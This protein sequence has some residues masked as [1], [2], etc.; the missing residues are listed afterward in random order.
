[1]NSCCVSGHQHVEFAKS[2]SNGPPVKARNELTR[3][4]VDAIDIANVAV[5]D[6]LVVIVLDLHDLVA[7]SE[8]PA[9][10]LNLLISGGIEC[11]LQFN[12]QRPCARAAA[13]H[14]TQ[15]LDVTDG[16]E[17]KPLWDPCFHK[18]DDAG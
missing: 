3:V 12:V 9:E 15:Y 18:L 6:L 13:V 16:I 10:T 7:G 4:G 11:S 1:M 2:V 5:V 8:R 17:P 14:R